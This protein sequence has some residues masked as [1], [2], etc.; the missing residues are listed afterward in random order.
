MTFASRADRSATTRARKVSS[1][2]TSELVE[3]GHPADEL[4]HMPAL[5]LIGCE[6]GARH[7]VQMSEAIAMSRAPT[8]TGLPR[9]S[10][11]RSERW[12]RLAVG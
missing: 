4:Q 6:D 8:C 9:R 3:V 7:R 12:R 10:R 5:R 2:L 11:E 1:T